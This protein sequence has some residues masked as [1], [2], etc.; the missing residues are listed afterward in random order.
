MKTK[1]N[2]FTLVILLVFLTDS[3]AKINNRSDNFIDVLKKYRAYEVIDL[4]LKNQ[5]NPMGVLERAKTKFFLNQPDE[6]INILLKNKKLFRDKKLQGQFH[7]LLARAYRLKEIFLKSASE[8]RLASTYLEPKIILREPGL[9]NFFKMVLIKELYK[10]LYS[11]RFLRPNFKIQQLRDLA[12]TGKSL[13]P[14]DEVFLKIIDTLGYISDKKIRLNIPDSQSRDFLI[15]LL[16][17]ISIQDTQAAQELIKSSQDPIKTIVGYGLL[18]SIFPISTDYSKKYKKD[19][20]RLP[21]L[22]TYLQLVLPIIKQQKDLWSIP[23]TKWPALLQFKNQ[24]FKLGFKHGN[25]LIDNELRSIL[26]SQDKKQI[27]LNLK[28]AYLLINHKYTYLR[29]LMPYIQFKELPTSL[30]ISI[31]LLTDQISSLKNIGLSGKEL[32][33]I[34][35]FLMPFDVNPFKMNCRF[36]ISI[37]ELKKDFKLYPL[38]YLL[39]YSYLKNIINDNI[40]NA[41]INVLKQAIFLY[42]DSILSQRAILEMAN[43]CIDSGKFKLFNKYINMFDVKLLTQDLLIEYYK[44]M[45]RFYRET[46]MIQKAIPYYIKIFNLSPNSLRPITILKIAL[47]VQRNNKIDLSQQLL[48]FLWNKKNTL[49][50]SLQAEILFWLAENDQIKGNTDKALDKYLKVYWFYKDQYIW[51]ITGLYRAAL[52]YE[53]IGKFDTAKRILM[54]VIKD[55]KRKSEKQAAISRLNAIKKREQHNIRALFLF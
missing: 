48:N 45:G 31:L 52:I 22:N 33:E 14:K 55:A 20:L 3:Y 2:L 13:W 39:R 18:D 35:L 25:S 43:R 47:F 28:L 27:L 8:Y 50:R 46:D 29:Q 53:Q 9:E 4:E 38:D 24:L 41:H 40:K 37:F 26:I 19:L 51:S 49:K 23:I 44:T 17:Y 36:N 54:D 12:N 10:D 5:K 16:G 34:V 30:K 11:G 1:I 42:P 15:K 32:K 21:K 6:T 7:L